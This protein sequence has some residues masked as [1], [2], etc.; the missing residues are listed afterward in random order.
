[1]GIRA[2]E[3]REGHQAVG[4]IGVPIVSPRRFEPRFCWEK[5]A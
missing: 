4:K 2:F 5:T 3:K 1:V